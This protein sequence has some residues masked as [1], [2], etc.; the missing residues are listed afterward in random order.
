MMNDISGKMA[1]K[2]DMDDMKKSIKKSFQESLDQISN[3]YDRKFE[4]TDKAISE[5]RGMITELKD[6]ANQGE[7]NDVETRSPPPKKSRVENGRS[8]SVDRGAHHRQSTRIDAVKDE[9]NNKLNRRVTVS[10]FMNNSSKEDREKRINI[11]LDGL[12][13]KSNYGAYEVFAK[14]PTGSEVVIQFATK[15]LAGQFV[16]DNIEEIKK[17][18]VPGKANVLHSAFFNLHKDGEQWKIYHATRFLAKNFATSAKFGSME[19]KGQKHKGLISIADFDVVRIRIDFEGDI[20]Y[21]LI[22]A[23][24]EDIGTEDLEDTISELIKL[25]TLQFK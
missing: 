19:V 9:V 7:G 11:F 22:K 1:S 5:I 10:N 14:G 6:K 4:E 20:D 17:F 25:F 13:K 21:T 3:K 8:A 23:N 12:G 15:E 18:K 24:I 2:D 16:R